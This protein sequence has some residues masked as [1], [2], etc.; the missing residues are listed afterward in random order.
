MRRAKCCDILNTFVHGELTPILRLSCT[1]LDSR[2]TKVATVHISAA[3]SAEGQTPDD[4]IAPEPQR[5]RLETGNSSS[6]S[7]R[8]LSFTAA[9][10][11]ERAPLP[12]TAVEV[13]LDYL[14]APQARR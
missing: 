12:D 4:M 5:Q 8:R 7:P 3:H 6:P 11:D 13:V 10:D 14:P 1:P 9:T 2:D